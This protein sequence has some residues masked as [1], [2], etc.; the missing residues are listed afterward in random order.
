MPI[1]VEY[2][3]IIP[4]HERRN[5][6]AHS[7]SFSKSSER[8][9]TKACKQSIDECHPLCEI[10]LS[11]L[12]KDLVDSTLKATRAAATKRDSDLCDSLHAV[13]VV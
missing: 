3:G 12:V 2:S 10:K 13:L 7:Q 9:T 8:N 6:I 11:R 1:M 4:S 5:S